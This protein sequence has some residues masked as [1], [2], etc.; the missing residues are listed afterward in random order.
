MHFRKALQASTQVQRMCIILI[1]WGKEKVKKENIAGCEN[2]YIRYCCENHFQLHQ[3]FLHDCFEAT[4]SFANW[5]H[6]FP[7]GSDFIKICSDCF[8]P[9]F[10]L[11]LK[12]DQD[13]LWL[14]RTSGVCAFCAFSYSSLCHQLLT[15]ISSY[16]P[17]NILVS[18]DKYLT[19]LWYKYPHQ[20]VIQ[21]SNILTLV[22]A[23]ILRS[24]VIFCCCSWLFYFAPHC[25]S[26][27]FAQGDNVNNGV[28]IVERIGHLSPWYFIHCKG[29]KL[30][31]AWAS[32][33]SN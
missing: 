19:N 31:S 3:D 24:A 29:C 4:I 15:Q 13:F 10:L 23:Q 26:V 5:C 6:H 25:R 32:N 20:I 7:F 9:A 17:T 16:P 8:E 27:T 21:I 14:F 28:V 11:L 18:W 2:Q 33:W 30:R 22:L 12:F 1:C